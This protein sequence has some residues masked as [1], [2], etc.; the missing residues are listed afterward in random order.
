MSMNE[1]ARGA[2]RRNEGGALTSFLLIVTLIMVAIIGMKMFPAYLEYFAVQRVLKSM[3]DAGETS[4]S[5][6]EIKSAFQRRASTNDIKN[7]T[8]DQL[9]VDKG[10][11]GSVVSVNY[12]VTIPLFANMKLVIDFSA[13]SAK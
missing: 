9:E 11:G 2:R 1:G 3:A 5:S 7:V 12:P 13:S 10:S 4:G 8:A 6:G